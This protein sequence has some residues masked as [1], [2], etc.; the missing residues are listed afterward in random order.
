MLHSKRTSWAVLL[1]SLAVHRRVYELLS[2]DIDICSEVDRLVDVEPP[3]IREIDSSWSSDER[4]WRNFGFRKT[5]FPSM[6]TYIYR[7]FGLEGVK[8][9]VTHYVLDHIES[10][11]YRGFDAEMLRDEVT[12]LIHNYVD[13]CKTQREEE[14]S[15]ATHI[16][17]QVLDEMLKRFDDVIQAVKHEVD[18]KTLPIDMVVNASS[19]LISI[20]LRGALIAMGYKGKKGF[21]VS[22]SIQSKYMQ[23]YNKVKQVLRQKLYEAITKHDISD[24]QKLLESINNFKKRSVEAKTVSSILQAIEEESSRNSDFSKLVEMV[25][26]CIEEAVKSA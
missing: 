24:V 21:T 15:S 17:L 2:L 22:S 23:L 10:L 5:E 4:V 11:L 9:L 25:K 26:Q 7:R 20:F 18:L 14:L 19:D 12:A 16:L 8:C 1:P 13:E 3:L 6:Y